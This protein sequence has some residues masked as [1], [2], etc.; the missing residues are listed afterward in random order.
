MA[1]PRI[2]YEPSLRRC[3]AVFI[4][5]VGC[6]SHSLSNGALFGPMEVL[7]MSHLWIG[8]G[9]GRIRRDDDVVAL[10][11]RLAD[12]T[13]AR[14]DQASNSETG[15]NYFFQELKDDTG[16][17]LDDYYSRPHITAEKARDAPILIVG[18]SDGSGTR[19]VV[20]LLGELGVP[21]LVDDDGTLDVH[22]PIL[23]HGETEKG[24]PPLVR[25][26]LQQTHSA[27]YTLESLPDDVRERAIEELQNF[28]GSYDPR[29]RQLLD[30]L[31]STETLAAENV[32]FGFKAPVSM[33]LLPIFLETFGRIKFLHIVR[34]GRDIA[35]SQ[36]TSPVD[37]FYKTFYTHAGEKIQRLRGTTNGKEVE[38]MQLWNDW[39][40]QV[41]EWERRN[42][43]GRTFDFLVIRTEDLLS[44]E[45]KFEN[46][47][48]LADFVGSPRTVNELCEYHPVV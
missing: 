10:E 47:V 42:A 46:L 26:I 48:K 44:P 25:L 43:D 19:A 27:D 23:F 4:I 24:W 1:Y 39:N 35:L 36:N 5:L 22:A 17:P 3:Q 7:M 14:L 31:E 29:V 9:G 20:G 2:I 28:E 34:D 8:N 21:M 16:T 6:F 15:L 33:L 41:L 12:Q 38:A 13:A 40:S 37:K 11:D 30:S 32:R 45:T 18:G